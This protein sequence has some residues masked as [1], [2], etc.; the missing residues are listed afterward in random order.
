MGD[1]SVRMNLPDAARRLQQTLGNRM[2]T[3]IAGSRDPKAIGGWI[4]RRGEALPR[5]Q[6]HA[7]VCL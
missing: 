4:E 7:F 6:H 2:V 5:P 3:T 1:Q